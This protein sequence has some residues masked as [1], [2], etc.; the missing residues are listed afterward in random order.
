MPVAEQ[1]RPFLCR[2]GSEVKNFLIGCATFV[3]LTKIKENESKERVWGQTIH[4]VTVLVLCIL[5]DDVLY[6]YQVL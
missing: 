1:K 3:S 5:S 2:Q 4:G 6:L